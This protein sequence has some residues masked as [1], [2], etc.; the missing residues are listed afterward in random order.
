MTKGSR[1]AAGRVKPPV[2]NVAIPRTIDLAGLALIVMFVAGFARALLLLGNTSALLAY[3]TKANRD[4]KKP[5]KNFD[6]VKAV[7][8]L[9][10]S[11]FLQ[12]AVIGVALLLLA[13][14]MRRSR[15][16][17]PTRW[18]LLIV[19]VF[20]G[21]PFYVIPTSGLPVPAQIAGILVGVSAIVTILLVFIP[22]TSVKYFKE[23][24]EANLPEDLRGKPRPGLGSLFGPKRP[25]GAA[26]TA[27]ATGTAAK[28]SATTRPAA[29][30]AKAK[31]R[32]D[33]DAVAKG[34]ELAR[35]RAKASKS[36][37]TAD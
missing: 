9:R 11:A 17:S 12:A 7:H 13:W 14:A 32:S 15:S 6:A 22:P 28:P 27:P 33:T 3:A 4:A 24:R 1:P 19:F 26:A 5:D 35:A 20:T 34:A 25:R 10:E 31:V 30:K 29:P 37:R 16:A 21:M 2:V 8:T 36:R 18:A 23:C